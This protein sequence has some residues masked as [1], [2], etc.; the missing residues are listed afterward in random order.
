MAGDP[1]IFYCFW[2]STFIPFFTQYANFNVQVL[3]RAI[4]IGSGLSLFIYLLWQNLSFGIILRQVAQSL[5][6]INGHSVGAFIELMGN[7]INKP[8]ITLILNSF[9][10]VAL[11]LHF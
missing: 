8:S 4:V 6:T 5:E 2:L 3:K 10:H 7:V 9:A 1:C 11:I